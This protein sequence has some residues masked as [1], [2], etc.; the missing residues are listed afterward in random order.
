[1]SPYQ[2]SEIANLLDAV[3]KPF[4]TDEVRNFLGRYHE[5][6]ATRDTDSSAANTNGI[7]TASIE[8]DSSAR[9]LVNGWNEVAF[10]IVS[11][12]PGA[13]F[14]VWQDVLAWITRAANPQVERLDQVPELINKA[15]SLDA[16]WEAALQVDPTLSPAW[17][18]RQGVGIAMLLHGQA[19]RIEKNGPEPDRSVSWFAVCDAIEA[20]G[21][22]YRSVGPIKD[23]VIRWITEVAQ[24]AGHYRDALDTIKAQGQKVCDLY[25][26]VAEL[27]QY[28]ADDK[29]ETIASLEGKDPTE[30]LVE[31]TRRYNYVI[32]Y[33]GEQTKKSAE[34]HVILSE[35]IKSL[36]DEVALRTTQVDKMIKIGTE[37]V[38]IATE[39]AGERDDAT[40][41]L[42]Q[43]RVEMERLKQSCRDLRERNGKLVQKGLD[44]AKT[45]ASLSS[46]LQG[47][48]SSAADRLAEYHLKPIDTTAL[49]GVAFDMEDLLVLRSRMSP[50][51]LEQ[52]SAAWFVV[53]DAIEA[54]G[55]TRQP[56]RTMTESV[57]RWIMNVG[58]RATWFSQV[59]EHIQ[60]E[61]YF[62]GD[63]SP[64]DYDG[65]G[66]IDRLKRID[67]L[68]RRVVVRDQKIR[69]L[70]KAIELIKP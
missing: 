49:D 43:H 40:S 19:R 28:W 50:G 66:I 17:D 69:D 7:D 60:A 36:E 67:E 64:K 46:N 65:A 33:H 3:L 34:R 54:T 27:Q 10:H 70:Y 41:A 8:D 42:G 26:E 1:M 15:K 35:T 20:T 62:D 31:L 5:R 53:C 32:Q 52:R 30:A 4:G 45:I 39:R 63:D 12:D 23:K 56:A 6:L 11:L 38:A 21:I 25:Q 44:D 59:E 61:A 22:P 37:S 16:A 55:V 68:E 48:V 58:E 47:M 29:A 18:T 14:L 13:R 2:E 57:V 9:H 24:D 51:A